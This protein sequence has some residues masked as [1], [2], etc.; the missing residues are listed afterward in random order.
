MLGRRRAELPLLLVITYR[1]DEVA[2][3]HPLR[4][5]LG[6]LVTGSRTAVLSL[7]PLSR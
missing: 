3:D 4:L 1:D 6:D 7:P 2:A 5:V